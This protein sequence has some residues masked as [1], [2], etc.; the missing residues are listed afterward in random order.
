MNNVQKL[1][2]ERIAPVGSTRTKGRAERHHS[3]HRPLYSPQLLL[4]QPL[5]GCGTAVAPPADHG[6]GGSMQR[7]RTWTTIPDQ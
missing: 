2:I 4:L 3:K 7:T 6:C 5:L 1:S